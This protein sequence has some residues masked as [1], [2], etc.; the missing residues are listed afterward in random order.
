[1]HDVEQRFVDALEPQ[2]ITDFVDEHDRAFFIKLIEFFDSRQE[3]KVQTLQNNRRVYN[4]DYLEVVALAKKYSQKV[5]DSYP[6]SEP[7]YTHVLGLI[8]YVEGDGMEVHWDWM[9]EECKN[10]VLS[11]VMYL[12]DDYLGGEITFPRLG[13][14]YHPKAGAWVS[15]P[16]LDRRFDHGVNIVTSGIRY[17]LAWCFT[18]DKEKAFK[19]YML[20]DKAE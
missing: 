14:E 2:V 3:L 13:K 11:S 1:M 5:F 15:Y 19:P 20:T 8:K 18:T 10:C 6:T 12:N 9:S 4:L 17:A 7:I 16:S